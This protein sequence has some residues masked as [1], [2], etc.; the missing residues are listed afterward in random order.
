MHRDI[1]RSKVSASNSTKKNRTPDLAGNKPHPI[2]AIPGV[3]YLVQ[4]Y[5]T[6]TLLL[7]TLLPVGT[8][9]QRRPGPPGLES[10]TLPL[11]EQLAAGGAH[12]G[13]YKSPR[14]RKNNEN[15]LAVQA[16][17]TAWH[18]DAMW[19]PPCRRLIAVPG[20]V[21]RVQVRVRPERPAGA[22]CLGA[23]FWYSVTSIFSYV[24]LAVYGLF[25]PI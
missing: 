4:V 22:R 3:D 19:A 7:N 20:S 12:F 6:R 11:D 9:I 13:T 24:S 8:L 17:P 2:R 15:C 21:G 1:L 23:E 10:S 25:P 5:Y 14:S 18:Q 16:W